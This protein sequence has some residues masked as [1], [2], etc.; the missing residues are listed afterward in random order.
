M[1]FN[2]T[3]IIKSYELLPEKAKKDFG[4]SV[5][6]QYVPQKWEREKSQLKWNIALLHHGK[7]ILRTQ[8]SAG[9]A[10]LPS[11]KANARWTTDYD[12]A[13]EREFLAGRYATRG[14]WQPILPNPDD[15]V[16]CLCSDAEAVDYATFADW[17]RDLGLDD[18]S[19]KAK[20]DYDAC[21]DIGL[22]MRNSLSPVVFEKL[23]EIYADW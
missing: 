16:A 1:E 6:V 13:L 22:R 18:D 9:I 5:L 15:I 17:A 4:L 3:V 20:A 2:H 10:H 19:I 14:K 11:F 23:R 8:F 12:G 7:E 21:L